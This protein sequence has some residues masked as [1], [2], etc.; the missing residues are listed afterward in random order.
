M[1]NMI[2]VECPYPNYSGE[3][4]N[5]T[6]DISVIGKGIEIWPKVAES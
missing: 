5:M 3:E 6:M 4:V 2:Q 1:S